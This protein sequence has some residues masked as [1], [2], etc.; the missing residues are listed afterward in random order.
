MKWNH[1]P[2]AGGL[3]AQHPDLIKGFEVIFEAKADH[4]AKEAAKEKRTQGRQRG[5]GASMRGM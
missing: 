3:Y 1:L 4:E 5:K 2:V